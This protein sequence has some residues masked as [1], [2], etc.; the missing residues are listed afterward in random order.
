MDWPCVEELFTVSAH[1]AL[2]L[3]FA[4]PAVSVDVAAYA[5]RVQYYYLHWRRMPRYRKR[6]P[7]LDWPCLGELFAVPVS[8]AL[9]L[10]FAVTAVSVD[11][12]AHAARVQYYYLHLR[13]RTIGCGANCGIAA[14]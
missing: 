13:P 5:S 10:A 14:N 8:A 4:V 3:A 9:L 7:M 11:I 12:A 1:A 2:L 6:R